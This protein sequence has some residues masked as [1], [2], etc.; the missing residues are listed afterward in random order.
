MDRRQVLRLT[1]GALLA[2]PLVGGCAAEPSGGPSASSPAPVPADVSE[3]VLDDPR[4][5]ELE[6]RYDARLGVSAVHV[7]SGRSVGHRVDERFALCSTFKVY[8]AGAL[9]AAHPMTD[10]F[11]TTPVRYTAA[12][13][14]TYSP[15][16]EQHVDT[17]L[18]PLRLCEAAMTQS[19]NTAGNLL[20]DQ[21]GGPP[22]L[23]AF[24][25]TIGDPVTRLDRRETELNSAIPGDDRDTT[26]PAAIA[27]GYRSL[28]LGDVL[29]VTEREQLREWMVATT[30]GEDRIRAAVPAGWTV[31]DKTGT[32][33]Y[34][35]AND[36][37]VAWSPAGEPLVVAVLSSRSSPAAEHDDALLADAAAVVVDLLA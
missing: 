18:T 29:G 10:P 26:T 7:T 1:L 28:V 2:A 8:A 20:L 25:R 27:A 6:R 17:G 30:T 37:A 12:D 19:D 36:V 5:A 32:G 23:T 33:G 35:T 34:A 3:P 11:W 21:L 16:T 14:V 22:A 24:A 4:F 31:G 13:L 15:V 9:L